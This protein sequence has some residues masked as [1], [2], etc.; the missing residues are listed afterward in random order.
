MDT[1]KKYSLREIE[2][3]WLVGSEDAERLLGA[4]PRI[5]GDKYL[6]DTQLRLRQ[7][8]SEDGEEVYKLCKKYGDKRGAIESITNIYLSNAEYVL[9][10]RLPGT[11]VEK[12]RHPQ[13]LGSI[14]VYITPQGPMYI[15]EVEF[16]SAEA[17]ASFQP[18]AFAGREITEDANLT[19]YELATLCADGGAHPR[20]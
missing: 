4:A 17:A 20:P 5:V 3:R 7:V 13:A 9:L 14:D 2:R 16:A 18:P 8:V 1:P 11:V 6:P 15:Y 10:D 12:S 19:G